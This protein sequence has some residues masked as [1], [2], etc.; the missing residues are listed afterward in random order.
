LLLVFP[1]TIYHGR[2]LFPLLLGNERLIWFVAHI[3][4]SWNMSKRAWVHEFAW[5]GPYTIIH[6]WHSSCMT[7]Q[8]YRVWY[9]MTLFDTPDSCMME[10]KT[11][12]IFSRGVLYIECLFMQVWTCIEM[13]DVACHSWAVLRSVN[14]ADKQSL[15]DFI[16]A[17]RDIPP[18]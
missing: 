18:L 2:V 10:I 5:S 17:Y 12:L 14:L 3:N 8:N 15:R 1:P 9:C 11:C 13:F 16:D 7:Y 6:V 4:A